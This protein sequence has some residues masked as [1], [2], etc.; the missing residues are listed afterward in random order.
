[1]LRPAIAHPCAILR[2]A[3]STAQISNTAKF[4]AKPIGNRKKT[5]C[6]ISIMCG[7]FL[8]SFSIGDI[9]NT[10]AGVQKVVILIVV[11]DAIDHDG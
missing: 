10:G 4:A 3:L 2:L 1:M 5:I 9:E 8:Y 6:G 11:G 7:D